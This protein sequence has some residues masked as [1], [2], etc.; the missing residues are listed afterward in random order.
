MLLSTPPEVYVRYCELL[1]DFDVRGSLRS[2]TA[3][4]VAIAGAEDATSPPEH[5]E[6]IAA[7]LPD[8]HLVVIP[9]AAHLANVERPDEFNEALLAHLA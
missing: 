4:T 8:A 9:G 2:I 3:P 5:L 1:K 6:A 7:E